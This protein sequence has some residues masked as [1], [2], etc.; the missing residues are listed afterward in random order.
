MLTEESLITQMAIVFMTE[1]LIHTSCLSKNLHFKASFPNYTHATVCWRTTKLCLLPL[2]LLINIIVQTMF[3]SKCTLEPIWRLV[4]L[5]IIHSN[6]TTMNRNWKQIFFFWNS[7]TID[8]RLFIYKEAVPASFCLC[9]FN[10]KMKTLLPDTQEILLQQN[11][12]P[13]L[14][15]NASLH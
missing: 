5:M 12:S 9:C 8:K 3:V 4:F 11:S 6:F 14:L 13:Y 10:K 2:V 15:Q 1:D 7:D